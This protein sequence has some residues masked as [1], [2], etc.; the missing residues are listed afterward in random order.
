ML[1]DL[2]VSFPTGL[3]VKRFN[4]PGIGNLTGI[5][6]AFLTQLSFYDSQKIGRLKPYK[7]GFGLIALDVFNLNDDN[8]QRDLG[9][10]IIGSLLPLRKDTRF[11]FPLYGGFGYLIKNNTW[12]AVFG[13]GIQF[14]F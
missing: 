13:P 10:V 14:N 11:S 1:L 2:Q 3:L 8:K 5:S 7:I 6:T 12:F 4:Q 9:L